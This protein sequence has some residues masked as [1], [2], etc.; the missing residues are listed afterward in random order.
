MN[1]MSFTRKPGWEENLFE[2]IK[3]VNLGLIKGQSKSGE[4][5]KFQSQLSSLQKELKRTC[6]AENF[7]RANRLFFHHHKSKLKDFNIPWY[8]PLWC[9]GYG[10]I[11][12]SDADLKGDIYRLSCRVHDGQQF[13]P[14][15]SDK[16]WNMHELTR[17]ILKDDLWA[18]DGCFFKKCNEESFDEAY[19][20]LI[21]STL[22]SYD[23]NQLTNLVSEIRTAE[24][25]RTEVSARKEKA[26][27]KKMEKLWN[28]KIPLTGKILEFED[29]II[30]PN[31]SGLAVLVA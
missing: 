2:E 26:Y 20:F 25:F 31:R 15:P 9:G 10:L 29:I 28:K 24:N 11:P 3:F 6:P 5:G 12:P 19:G 27:W 4:I 17:D 23:L 8:M 13:R 14:P 22:F 21:A 16:Q 7:E 1:S 30:P 18:I